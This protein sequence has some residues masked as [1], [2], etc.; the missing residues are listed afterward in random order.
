MRNR[1]F[2]PQLLFLI[3]KAQQDGMKGVMYM[4]TKERILMIRLM[5]KLEKNPS[6]AKALGIEASSAADDQ[7]KT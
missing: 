2:I 5:E 4:G 3:I 7:K 6:C 1:T